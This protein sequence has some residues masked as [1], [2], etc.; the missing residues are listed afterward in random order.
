MQE[1]GSRQRKGQTVRGNANTPGTGLANDGLRTSNCELNL[2]TVD[3]GL[4]PSAW[5][6]HPPP[7]ATRSAVGFIY[8]FLNLLYPV[9]GRRTSYVAV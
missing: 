9:F 2:Q 8:T 1:A 4:S 6:A 5:P 7:T 3:C